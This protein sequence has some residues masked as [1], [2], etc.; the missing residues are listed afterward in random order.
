M[1]ADLIVSAAAIAAAA[2]TLA[3]VTI[4]L[5]SIAKGIRR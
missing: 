4:M 5:R 3:P 2:L 1:L